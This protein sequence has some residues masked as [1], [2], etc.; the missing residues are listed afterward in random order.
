M[1]TGCAFIPVA[2]II[3]APSRK[4]AFLN[5]HTKNTLWCR[6]YVK[7]PR[8]FGLEDLSNVPHSKIAERKDND[9][10][11]VCEDKGHI[12]RLSNEQLARHLRERFYVE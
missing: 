1:L 8:S 7:F 11:R 6:D 3:G 9:E 5:L 4:A 12:I 10:R 2:I